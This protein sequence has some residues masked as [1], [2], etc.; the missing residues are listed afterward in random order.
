[1]GYAAIVVS[2]IIGIIFYSL[3]PKIQV[4][5]LKELAQKVLLTTETISVVSDI[6]VTGDINLAEGNLIDGI[7]LSKFVTETNNSLISLQ[8]QSIDSTENETTDEIPV[9][10]DNIYY[11]KSE[12]DTKLKKYLP[13]TGG[14][15]TGGL[16]GTTAGFTSLTGTLTGNVVGN[17]TG[18]VSGNAGGL[19]GNP[20]ITISG[21][22]LP[23]GASLNYVLTSDANGK[24]TWS[25]TL[26]E[27]NA[28][29]VSHNHD[30]HYYSQTQTTTLLNS[31]LRLTGGTLTGDLLGT[32]ATFTTFTGN[33]IGDVTG[34]VTGDLTGNVIGNVTGI[35]TGNVVGNVTGNASGTAGGLS[36]SPS[37]TIGGITMPT[38]AGS[39]YLLT[40][41]ANGVGTWQANSSPTLPSGTE[42]QTLYNN[43]GTWAANSGL[44]YDDTNNRVGI[45]TTSPVEKFSIFGG[46]VLFENNSAMSFVGKVASSAHP[47]IRPIFYGYRARGTLDSPL[48]VNTN[49]HLFSFTGGGYDGVSYGS[50]AE[51]ATFADELW[52]E[53]HHGGRIVFRTRA[54]DGESPID[55][56]LINSNGNV[57]IGTTA[58]DAVLEVFKNTTAETKFQLTNPNAETGA[59]SSIVLH[60]A[61]NYGSLNFFGS[62]FTSGGTAYQNGLRLWTDGAGGISFAAGHSQAPIRFFSGGASTSS[63]I[64]GT[65]GNVGIGSTS[66]ENHLVVGVGSANG[67]SIALQDASNTKIITGTGI[68]SDTSY[69]SNFDALGGIRM[70]LD[71]D[72]NS[73]NDFRV[74]DSLN[75]VRL[76]IQEDGNV[77]IGTTSPTTALEIRGNDAVATGVTVYNTSG[78]SGQSS[79]ILLS[80]SLFPTQYQV[81]KN[82][83][84][85]G[86][87]DTRLVFNDSGTDTMTIQNTNVGIGVGNN[88]PG[89]RLQVVGADSLNTSF[90]GNISGLTGTGLVVTNAGNVGI[91]TTSPGAKLQVNGTSDASQLI[92]RANATQSNTNPL[93]LLQKSDGT[94]FFGISSD[95]DTNIFIG[96]DSGRV[97]NQAGG[98]WSN[99]FVGSTAGYSNTAGTY[100]VALGSQAL[101]SN[102]NGGSNIAIGHQA[103]RANS[104]TSN[105]TAIGHT[106]L[107]ST[108]AGNNT[109]LGYGSGY[110]N[111]TGT[112]N[113]FIGYSAGYSETA[114]NKLYIENSN[115]ASPLIW[116]DFNTDVVNINGSLGIGTT[117]PGSALDVKGTLRLSGATSGYVDLAPAAAAG[118]TTY[119]LPSADGVSGQVLSTN[120]SAVL[121]WTS[122]VGFAN[123]MTG[124]GDLITQ[125]TSGNANQALVSSGATATAYHISAGV[126]NNAIDGDDGTS[127]A[128]WSNDS[129][130][131]LRVDLGSAKTIASYRLKK[132]TNLTGFRLWYS[133]N[134]TDWVAA[135]DAKS[136]AQADVTFTLPV[137]ISARYWKL[138]IDVQDWSA[139]YTMELRTPIV[140]SPQTLTIGT[141][142]QILAVSGG[143]PV[144]SNLAT[145]IGSIGN[146]GIGTTN[147]TQVLEVNGGIRQNTV[148]AKPTCDATTR[149]TT[150]FTQ[151]AAG[152]K[153][154]YEVCAKDAGDAYSWRTIY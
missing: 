147:P 40:S 115:S 154:S 52:N 30:T 65:L 37:I 48:P 29:F 27:L 80:H 7:D 133:T 42:G 60:N 13:L 50:G 94:P 87:T 117:A 79:Q 88:D 69:D 77:G 148:T 14:T 98:G 3:F 90:A 132:A 53:T 71:V 130:Q 96:K 103:L 11:Q 8:D 139:L 100:N 92:V 95:H 70:N 137:Q 97:N 86:G 64:I 34:D 128:F 112:G 18:D 129:G 138:N 41:D 1:M 72:N 44:Y 125:T 93:I 136:N 22:T 131:W 82:I 32:Q 106:A 113:I 99:T 107:R 16:V 54:T 61:T 145:I 141:T 63:V 153:D 38:S 28:S 4:D 135:D 105:N 58:P 127:V 119:T 51:V 49:D 9:N 150:W 24:A 39:G 81:I 55:R 67:Q 2:S 56:L 122:A 17:V 146:V 25:N 26:T 149:G 120:G 85:P 12:V 144:W 62:G 114:S 19:A 31:Y 104:T 109:A 74:I 91:G 78:S 151:G 110:S 111:S 46:N 102:S 20:A 134:D 84:R 140:T 15:L 118:S 152:V 101:Y 36:G 126:A 45:G 73:T 143:M 68:R 10:Y 124:T 76:L 116:G 43:A 83:L 89:A 6:N 66:P 33:V 47:A 57:G 75:N 59:F 108:T 123:P 21:L 5:F 121:S 35:H 142:N 23:T